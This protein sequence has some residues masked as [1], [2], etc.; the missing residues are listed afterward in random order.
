M[1]KNLSHNEAID[2]L[3]GCA[4]TVTLLSYQE[5]IEG[6][7]L[8]RGLKIPP[9][10]D[11]DLSARDALKETASEAE[12]KPASC[13]SSPT[14]RCIVDSSMESGPNNCFHCERPMR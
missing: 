8:L 5:V 4:L 9:D 2:A 11:S 1:S 3:V 14:G 6:Y 7:F 10:R 13:P 12:P